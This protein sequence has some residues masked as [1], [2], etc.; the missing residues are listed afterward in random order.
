M[1]SLYTKDYATGYGWDS[2]AEE[3]NKKGN[4]LLVAGAE[5]EQKRQEKLQQ[6][7][8]KKISLTNEDLGKFT[9]TR[10]PD[11]KDGY[12]EVNKNA[13][14]PESITIPGVSSGYYP[15]ELVDTYTSNESVELEYKS[16]YQK[17]QEDQ[18]ESRH[19]N[20]GV[21]GAVGQAIVGIPSGLFKGA[22][23]LVDVAQEIATYPV[24]EAV[25]AYTGNDKYDIDLLS[26]DTKKA[27]QKPV[28][29]LIGYD[30]ELADYATNKIV[31]NLKK[32][33]LDITNPSSFSEAFTDDSKL[34]SIIEATKLV[35][36][37]PGLVTSG[38][39]EFFGSAG[40]LGAG[41]KL[42][43]KV[44]SKVSPE[45]TEKAGEWFINN[46]NQIVMEIKAIDANSTLD[47]A[48]KLNRINDL[49]K[50][51][52]LSKQI[53]DLIRGST[54]SNATLAVALNE[55]LD[56]YKENNNGES[57]SPEKVL[58]MFVIRKVMAEIE[59]GVT[60][61][62][63]KLDDLKG[64]E[65]KQVTIGALG[66]VIED[67]SK[68]GGGALLEAGQETLDG[69]AA[70]INQKYESAKY[71]DKNA[72]D[73]LREDSAEIL[74]GTLIGGV[75]GAGV[76][77]GGVAV[78]KFKDTNI[79]EALGTV[80]DKIGKE[81][82]GSQ[83]QKPTTSVASTEPIQQED[84]QVYAK[85]LVTLR[86]A[87]VNNK[88]DK[89][90]I[91]HYLDKIEDAYD[92]R[93]GLVGADPELLK[94]A[95]SVY[96]KAA[97]HLNAMVVANPE[98]KL[99]PVSNKFI[100][101]GV[102]GSA[103]STSA[104]PEDDIEVDS[105]SSDLAERTLTMILNANSAEETVAN[106]DKYIRFGVVNGI[107][108]EEV[109]ALV[110]NYESVEE[111]ATVGDRGYITY[112]SRAKS[113]LRSGNPDQ[114]K[115]A[116][117]SGRLTKFM[118]STSKSLDALLSLQTKA[119]ELAEKNTKLGKALGDTKSK[120]VKGDYVGINGKPF[121]VWVSPTV[122]GSWVVQDSQLNSLIE[123]KTRTL[124]N[125][126]GIISTL[127]S[128]QTGVPLNV[129]QMIIPQ[130]ATTKGVAEARKFDLDNISRSLAAVKDLVGDVKVTKVIVDEEQEGHSD[131]WKVGSDYWNA[132]T[133]IINTG[134]YTA[135]DAV[136][137]HAMKTGKEGHSHS[138]SWVDSKKGKEPYRVATELAQA[139][140]AGATVVLDTD[141]RNPRTVKS[142]EG[143]VLETKGD[144]SKS[145]RQVAEYLVKNGYAAVPGNKGV[146]VKLSE[147]RKGKLKA[148]EEVAKTK[149]A[150]KND[151]KD[152][153]EKLKYMHAVVTL[154]R[155][156]DKG[157][158]NALVTAEISPETLDKVTAEYEELKARVKDKWFSSKE[159]LE[160]LRKED[161][162][163]ISA[164]DLVVKKT[165]EEKLEAYLEGALRKAV[166]D[167]VE[168][169]QSGSTDEDFPVASNADTGVPIAISRKQVIGAMAAREVARKAD[170]DEAVMELLQKWKAITD[171][172]LTA[173]DT[174][175][176][177]NALFLDESNK[178]ALQK[179]V[180]MDGNSLRL[181]RDVLSMGSTVG[182]KD[183]YEV[184][185]PKGDGTY[186]VKYVDS[187]PTDGSVTSAVK[188]TTD[189]SKFAKASKDTLLSMVAASVLP[190]SIME[191]VAKVEKTLKEKVKPFNSDKAEDKER[192]S[193]VDSPSRGLLFSVDGKMSPQVLSAI[194]L[195]FTQAVT[196]DKFKLT[197]GP[198][199]KAMVA[200]MLGITE[201]EVT[202][203]QMAFVKKHGMLNKLFANSLGKSILAELG[204][205]KKSGEDIN[206]GHY[207]TLAADL[208]NMAVLVAEHLGWVESTEAT[209][210]EVTAFYGNG[211]ADARDK[212]KTVKHINVKVNSKNE[213]VG[214]LAK[215]MKVYDQYKDVLPTVNFFRKE[216]VSKLS[217]KV[218]EDN[219]TS[220]RNDLTGGAHK[221][222]EVA[223]ATL[224]A[225]MRT[226]F[227]VDVEG[228]AR[229]EDQ[230]SAN[231]KQV[232]EI[233]GWMDP[234][235]EQFKNLL[236]DDKDVQVATNR[237]VEKSITE[238]L[239]LR[240]KVKDNPTIYFGAYYTKNG[241]YMLDSNT[242]NPQ[243]DKL[244][245]FFIQ[246][247]EHW[248]T[249]TIEGVG[250]EAR[251]SVEGKD[252]SYG[253]RLAL[254]QAF[255]EDID[256]S[257]T[258]DIAT[259]GSVL[260]ALD[261]EMLN[262]L[263]RDVIS[264][265]EHVVEYVKDGI[266]RKLKVKPVH[267]SHLLQ[268][269]DFL[270]QVKSG[271]VTSGLSAEFDSVTNGF[272]NKL[273]QLPILGGMKEHLSRVGI[274]EE[275]S[276]DGV[277][278]LGSG[279][280]TNKL[281]SKAGA[282]IGFLDS[283]KNLAKVVSGGN[284]KATPGTLLAKVDKY[285]P[286]AEADG[287][288]SSELRSLFKDPFMTFN[289][290][291][292]LHSIRK[293]LKES[294]VKGLLAKIAKGDKV[295]LEIAE[296]LV[297]SKSKELLV[298]RLRT[299][300]ASSIKLGSQ[301]LVSTLEQQIDAVYGAMVDE[302][303]TKNFKPYIDLQ[304]VINDAYRV[305]FRL[306]EAELQEEMTKL[307]AEKKVVTDKDY[308]ALIE[309]LWDRF[310]AIK[311]PLSKV[312]DGALE[313]DDIPVVDYT[314]RSSFGTVPL[315]DRAQTKVHSVSGNASTVVRAVMKFLAEAGKAGSVLPFHYIDGAE[316]G[317]TL[318]EVGGGL[319]PIHD[320]FIAPITKFDDTTFAYNKN[321]VSVNSRYALVDSLIEMTQRWDMV[322][323][324][325]KEALGKLEDFNLAKEGRKVIEGISPKVL[326]VK[327]RTELEK[328][329]ATVDEGKK[330]FEGNLV[331]NNMV[332]T[333]GGYYQKG[334]IQPNM[335]YLDAVTKHYGNVV[336]A[337]K[338][339]S[340][341]V[342][343]ELAV[344]NETVDKII[345]E[346]K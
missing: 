54:M 165:P 329:K 83:E 205:S 101:T 292:S 113:L 169:Y 156:Q 334:M 281:L 315:R 102:L 241:R 79:G 51:Y 92:V 218:I 197:K 123:A 178:E 134:N 14:Q 264:K 200:E 63:F 269:I 148:L 11:Y 93:L 346:C 216:P 248:L 326:A 12:V 117:V 125:I 343:Q 232:K 278:D 193:R 16:P 119:Q 1:E 179:L 287:S 166:Q 108:K 42:G 192:Y 308:K 111:E 255:G 318:L 69:I 99:S 171:K 314:S 170:A 98:W 89:D 210:E 261:E 258:E 129:G 204:I 190:T 296:S 32:S 284:K 4:D 52:T 305:S 176:E 304:N 75:G 214:E 57:A 24:Q 313:G 144:L 6:A 291:S 235:S 130:N 142:K 110:K 286:K 105:G 195:S 275:G 139:V 124:K 78:D 322:K 167:K 131:K 301:Y 277:V 237:E 342:S 298:N 344:V 324:D 191:E 157:D 182:A 209:V 323:L 203:Q 49:E 152:N 252:T 327:V 122:N 325:K 316:L 239:S 259:M 96:L 146:F 270:R 48:T 107:A 222:P 30:R 247:S 260:L 272:M 104:V 80:V 147:E 251:F 153:L 43:A 263:E 19:K 61:K 97:K 8:N 180:D 207:E 25:K 160:S 20:Q 196:A 68:I 254:V 114:E 72:L 285:L 194:W 116:A 293:R 297:G 177:V 112:A 198:K 249:H 115:L 253:V 276:F 226:P 27:V 31:D 217:E 35:V 84:R 173:E 288:I 243:S 201:K 151:R 236:F 58:E 187:V 132:N 136:L 155:L 67:L 90:N 245:R 65:G 333:P 66:T 36:T 256:K 328:A 283:Y 85:T 13:L 150:E 172:K 47:K 282:A 238:L 76:S 185:I 230:L 137:L 22:V 331:Y 109:E 280:V 81:V 73:I 34:D 309:K 95:D 311:G 257:S 3:L 289:Y 140:Q 159:S 143:K 300:A 106:K 181:A 158:V 213:V 225:I 299:E 183:I 294:M 161:I 229:F 265:G 273:M 149:A 341:V 336:V 174:L 188:I 227:T 202:D 295:G 250:A 74:A 87:I 233:L 41:T 290:S 168:V 274:I 319:T 103:P 120:L 126:T 268:G 118:T 64:P 189:I 5:L 244:H 312:V 154:K 100:D 306:F 46:K 88:I 231:E 340:P 163:D 199:S 23:D 175:V 86:D 271:T 59:T 21:L 29:S 162:D 246:P 138:V 127:N 330:I 208:G 94:T 321:I 37:N 224:E 28:D 53:P 55:D 18:V 310:P 50:T 220:V 10:S 223:Q 332:G 212:N 56:R 279:E 266:E 335:R 62:L 267:L 228:I 2:E 71:A 317:T 337:R 7:Q 242:V 234:E 164:D 121:D 15:K 44:A 60:R 45:V 135:N 211:E 38:F 206:I 70:S 262:V 320:A 345:E 221:V 145:G 303:F 133:P 302:A 17:Y 82:Q 307:Q 186:L 39:A 9:S 141:Y 240:D 33:G 339:E 338:E 215:T 40:A 184:T 26:D 128:K 91:A 77:A 219:K